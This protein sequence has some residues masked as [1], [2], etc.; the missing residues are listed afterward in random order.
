ME[1]AVVLLE[2][3][4]KS[5][6]N[7]LLTLEE[8]VQRLINKPATAEYYT[9]EQA[10]L[11]LKMHPDT[12]RKWLKEPKCPIEYKQPGRKISI[13]VRSISEYNNKVTVHKN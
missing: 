10:A 4:Y 1:S 12:L 6:T 13:S 3:E 7:R 9:V 11:S 2:S 5:L 8:I